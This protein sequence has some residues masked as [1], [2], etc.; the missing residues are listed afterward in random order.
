VAGRIGGENQPSRDCGECSDILSDDGR[1][2]HAKHRE[3]HNCFRVWKSARKRRRERQ[4]RPRRR[5]G[6]F[7]WRPGGLSSDL[8]QR[9]GGRSWRGWRSRSGKA[10]PGWVEERLAIART[11]LPQA[12]AIP[13]TMFA[14]RGPRGRV[15]RLMRQELILVVDGT[16]CSAAE[17]FHRVRLF[18]PQ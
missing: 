11:L 9:C 13:A 2:F 18:A 8:G 5:P 12:L 6:R 3:G 10:S 15:A 4:S 7:L 14:P 17:R 1:A 16:A